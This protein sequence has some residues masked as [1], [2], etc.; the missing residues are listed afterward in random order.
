MKIHF[1]H[2]FECTPDELWAVLDDP[3]FDALLEERS[4]VRRVELSREEQGEVVRS[5]LECTSLHELPGF[6]KRVLGADTLV[7]EQHGELDRVAG[8]LRWKVVPRVIADRVAASGTTRVFAEGERT[9]R[10]V[11]GDIG[12]R[13]RLVGGQLESL[14]QRL[15]ERSYN[16]A[17]E[18]MRELLARRSA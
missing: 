14:L 11:H 9:V 3:D 7:Y 16:N 4:Q 15:V 12:V 2:T 10:E 13:V 5:V 6:A 18:T 8:T 1:R 17:A